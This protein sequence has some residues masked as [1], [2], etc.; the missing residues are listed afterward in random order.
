MNTRE[1]FREVMHFN[2]SVLSLKLD[3]GFWS[4][5]IKRWYNGGVPEKQYPTIA[6]RTITLNSPLYTYA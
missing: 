2:P 4:S 1:R 3:S 5:T 6:T